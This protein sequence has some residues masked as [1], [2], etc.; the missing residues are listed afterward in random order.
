MPL[1]REHI[2]DV[3]ADVDSYKHFL[4]YCTDSAILHRSA[5]GKQMTA[6]MAVGFKVGR[7]HSSAQHADVCVDRLDRP[8]LVHDVVSVVAPPSAAARAVS[9]PY[10]S[11]VAAPN[12]DPSTY[13]AARTRAKINAA[14][15]LHV[16]ETS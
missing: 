1:R 10:F 3:V 4:P 16:P 9:G 12:I 7:A 13:R 11:K 5:D 15:H 8:G 6:A 2:F 14:A